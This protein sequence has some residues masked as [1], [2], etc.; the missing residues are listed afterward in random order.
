MTSISSISAYNKAS[1]A[2][3]VGS[4]PAILKAANPKGGNAPDQ[5]HT[6]EKSGDSAHGPAVKVTLS[7]QADLLLKQQKAATS[8]GKA[9]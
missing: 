4:A 9:A 2:A 1:S 6:A 5:T 8:E 7:P 3:I